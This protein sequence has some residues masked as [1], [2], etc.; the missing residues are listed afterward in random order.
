ML[1]SVC[2]L[3]WIGEEARSM[4]RTHARPPQS[5]ANV[6]VTVDS[7]SDGDSES[8]IEPVSSA[9]RRFITF[10]FSTFAL[11]RTSRRRR[12]STYFARLTEI[13]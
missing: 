11:F 10:T 13:S 7:L 2:N 4:N 12:R 9:A 5:V 6:A 8:T 3:V 1:G